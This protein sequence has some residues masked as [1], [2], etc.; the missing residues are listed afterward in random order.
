MGPHF[1]S[2]KGPPTRKS[3]NCLNRYGTVSEKDNVGAIIRHGFYTT[4]WG[5]RRCYQCWT[6]GKTF[7]STNGTPHRLQHRCS[8]LDEVASLSF[9]SLNRSAIVRVKGVAWNTVHRWLEKAAGCCLRFSD[10]NV[11][12]ALRA[13]GSS[14]P[15]PRPSQLRE[16]S[17]GAE[18]WTGSQST[19]PIGWAEVKTNLLI[20]AA[21][22]RADAIHIRAKA[23]A[24]QFSEECVLRPVNN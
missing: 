7:C 1:Y 11:N 12:W 18:T 22:C 13:G 17:Q 8:T 10:R 2:R 19:G 24:D 9:E 20:K 5:K 6:R 23:P 21:S 4:R 14:K 15:A 3:L 16:A